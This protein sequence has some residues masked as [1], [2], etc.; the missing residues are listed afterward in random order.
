VSIFKY[1][2]PLIVLL[3]APALSAQTV[4]LGDSFSASS[5]TLSFGNA[6]GGAQNLPSSAQWFLNAGSSIT[7]S[8]VSDSS[9]NENLST[10]DQSL[11]AYF[12]NAGTQSLSAG[13][14]ID[15]SF[16]F[17]MSGT[18]NI[19]DGI[20]VGFLN[21]G[22][23]RPTINTDVTD[24]SFTSYTGYAAFFNPTTSTTNLDARS[25]ANTN[26]IASSAAYGSLGAPSV[27]SGTPFALTS[28][29]LTVGQLAL[30][31]TGSQMIVT[32]GLT[33]TATSAQ[34]IYSLTTSTISATAFDTIV[35]GGLSGA[36]GA[37]SLSISNA[38][39]TFLTVPEPPVYVL[40]A[41]GLVVLAAAG[42]LSRRRTARMTA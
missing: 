14:T 31:Y 34:V 21:S 25:S 22:G 7:A 39:V 18:A 19:A 17:T 28:G 41:G 13:D 8:Y 15:A 11:T 3:A 38:S 2:L 36:A 24:S 32:F 16:S 37:G 20:R 26:L 27:L 30:T 1:C 33:D 12:T 29:D 5:S 10:G 35:I 40:C 9:I 42:W 6:P 4:L 23:S